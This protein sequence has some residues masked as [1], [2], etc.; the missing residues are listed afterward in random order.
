MANHVFPDNPVA[1]QE[2]SQSKGPDAFRIL[3]GQTYFSDQGELAQLIGWL[4]EIPSGKTLAQYLQKFCKT[5]VLQTHATVAATIPVLVPVP[6]TVP[7]LMR[8]KMVKNDVLIQ[9]PHLKQSEIKF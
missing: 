9:K 3:K 7:D 4:A 5:Q 6:A 2:L 8:S 1:N